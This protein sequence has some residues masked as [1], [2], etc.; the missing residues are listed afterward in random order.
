MWK[1]TLN[2]DF[3]R[4]QLPGFDSF[5]CNLS[6]IQKVC[7]MLA[8][9][10][11]ES[12]EFASDKADVGEIDVAIHHIGHDVS[13]QFAAQHI[14]SDQQS[15]QVV[16]FGI[17][18]RRPLFSRDSSPVPRFQNALDGGADSGLDSWRDFGPLQ[19]RKLLELSVC[20][21]SRRHRLP[22]SCCVVA[23]TEQIVR[24]RPYQL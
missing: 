23:S 17:C 18:Q 7:V 2:A 15:E 21:N 10:T 19:W 24:S 12:A 4:A 8:R 22:L 14:G 11:A 16:A 5:L 3:G 9:A 1:A 6:W 13:G 20:A